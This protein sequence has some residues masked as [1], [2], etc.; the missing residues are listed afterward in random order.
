MSER[1]WKKNLITFARGLCTHAHGK[2][3]VTEWESECSHSTKQKKRFQR[4]EQIDW[5]K[6][7][8]KSNG[9]QMEWNEIPSVYTHGEWLKT[10]RKITICIAARHTVCRISGVCEP[11]SECVRVWLVLAFFFSFRIR[12]HPFFDFVACGLC[13][14]ILWLVRICEIEC[15]DHSDKTKTSVDSGCTVCVCVIWYLLCTSFSHERIC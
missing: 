4:I 12:V 9:G 10:G 7:R 15:A 8:N 13:Y 14:A 2:V 3:R 5:R 6:T 11:A 1:A